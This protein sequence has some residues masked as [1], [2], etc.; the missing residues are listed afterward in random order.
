MDPF[1]WR[2]L[3]L[4]IIDCLPNLSSYYNLIQT[5]KNMRKLCLRKQENITQKFL[6]YDNDNDIDESTING[7]YH[8][9]HESFNNRNHTT[10]RSHFRYGYG[11]VYVF[12]T[13]K[14]SMTMTNY[15]NNKKHGVMETYD[16]HKKLRT[17]CRFDMDELIYII[18]YDKN[19]KIKYHT[20]Y[21]KNR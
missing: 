12:N 18:H 7:L 14:K 6:I 15:Y 5:C 16:T 2:D 8:Y 19:G 13:N 3:W 17:R 1:I 20:N 21:D 11:I 10:R 4:I 9:D